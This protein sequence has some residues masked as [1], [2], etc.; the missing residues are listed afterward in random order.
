MKN[1][2]IKIWIILF[3]L[4]TSLIDI[5]AQTTY[6]FNYTG[7][8]QTFT[9]PTSGEYNI[10]ALGA[11][12]GN[13]ISYYQTRGGLGGRTAGSIN[14]TA[15]Q[16]IYIYVGGKSADQLGNHPY[17][18]CYFMLGGWNGGGDNRARGNGTAGGGASDVRIGG[19]NLNNRIIVAGG[20]G[21]AGWYV[22]NGGHGGGLTGGD[23]TNW[24]QLAASGGGTQVNGGT[25]GQAGGPCGKSSGSFGQGGDGSGSSAGGGGGG[26]G[27]YGGGGGGFINGGGGGSSYIGGVLNGLAERGVHTG[28]GRVIITSL[29]PCDNLIP[30]LES[31]P[32]INAQCEVSTLTPPSAINNC[33][34]QF[35]GTPNVTFPITTQGT[36]VVTWTYDDGN[37]N[38]ATQTQNVIIN[39]SEAPSMSFSDSSDA[40]ITSCETNL[41]IA[42]PTVG[43]NCTVN[44]ALDFDGTND[45]IIIQDD[46]SLDITSEITIEAWIRPNDISGEKTIL[47]KGTSNQCQNYLLV[48]RDGKLAYGSNGNCGWAGQG[49]N[50]NITAD[51]WQH[52]AAVAT[53]N[54]LKLYINGTLK[55]EIPLFSHIGTS[56]NENLWIGN[57][58]AGLNNHF[59]GQI[60]EVRIWNKARSASEIA[61]DFDKILNGSE[62]GLVAYYNFEDG[63]G[64]TVL[65]DKSVNANNGVLTNMAPNT[66]WISADAPIT[67]VS[68]TNSFTGTSNASGIYPVGET[69]VTWTAT[70]VAGN[71]NTLQQ[72]ITAG[73]AEAPEI[74]VQDITVDAGQVNCEAEVSV[75]TPVATDNCSNGNSLAFD[76]VDDFVSLG[77][78]GSAQTIEFWMNAD[79]SFDPSQEY[80]MLFNFNN[81]IYNYIATGN[82]TG[83]ISGETL[84]I[85]ALT[86]GGGFGVVS[87][88]EELIGW[89]HIA[90]V[91]N[92]SSYSSIYVNGNP[93]TVYPSG[94]ASVI[95]INSGFIGQ[96]IDTDT[97]GRYHG[98]LDEVRFWNVSRSGSEIKNN[99]EKE[100]SSQSGIIALYNFNQGL[101]NGD[102]V[103]V[104][105]LSDSSGNANNGSLNNFEIIG[106][107]SNWVGGF[108]GLDLIN[109]I[110]GT[111]NASGLYP[112]GDTEITWTATD[113]SGNISTATQTITVEDNT[114]PNAISQNIT[115]ELDANGQASI[116]AE[117]MN[118][119]STDNCEIASMELSQYDFDCTDVISNSNN[120]ALSFDGVDDYV[121]T[122]YSSTQN[123]NSF[124]IEAW[125]KTTTTSYSR[126]VTKPAGGGQNY[127]LMLWAGGYPHIRF[128]GNGGQF[129]Q[130]NTSV[131]DGQ[132]HHLAGVHNTVA[133]TITIY[134]DGVAVNTSNV[135]GDPVTSSEPLFIGK[136]SNT[137]NDY[138]NGEIDEVRL[139]NIPRSASEISSSYNQSLTGTEIG[140]VS[141]Y[142]FDDGSGTVLT[143]KTGNSLNGTLQ[144]MDQ[145]TDWVSGVPAIDIS[146]SEVVLTVTDINGNSSTSTSVVTVEDNLAPIVVGKNIE[147]T[148]T[149]TG[150]VSIVSEDVLDNGSDN[151]GE[152]T[153]ALSQDEFGA[154]DAIDSPVTIQLI[155]TDAHGNETS[156]PVIITVIDP[157]PN[158]VC[159]PIKVFLDENG[160]ITL[161]QDQIDQIG[162]GS[163]SVVG[164]G[165]LSVNINTFNC[166]NIGENTVILTVE[167]TLG[168]TATCEAVVTVEDN[169][170]PVAIAKD[171]T[172]QLD[173]NG[174]ASITAA[175]IDNGSNDACG[176]ASLALSKTDFNCSN[177]GA[178]TVTL[179]VTDNN[180][181]V[182]T[183]TA[184]ITV[185]DNVPP[186]AIAK[187]ITVQLDANGTASITAADID[188]G[189]NDAC[190]IAS[191]ALDIDSFT[192]S[193]VGDNTVVLTVTDNNGN[194]SSASAI[195]DVQDTIPAEVITQNIIAQLDEFGNVSIT[196]EDID[197][198]SND[199]CGIASLALD[200]DSFTC[201][202]VGDNTVVL[203][204]TDNNG[205]VSSASAIVDVQD[206]VPAEVITQNIIAQLDEF[207]NVSI[208]PEDIDNGSNDACGIASLA[209]D[210]DS[211]TCSNVGDNTVVLTVTD[212][213]GNVSS[214]SAIVDVQDTIPAE[215]ITQNIVAQLDEFG[216]VSITPEDIDNGSNDACG[217]AS[218]ALDIDSFTCSN[219]GDNTVVLTVTD[220]NGNVS[221]ASAIVDV[222]DTIPA[223][224]ITQNIVAQLD[225]FG[226]VSITPEDIDNGSND[227]CGIA[228]L[229]LDIDS[230]TCSNVGDN[231]VVL[232][233]TDNNGNVS[234]ASAIVDVQDTVPAE[235]ITQNIVAQLDEF[236]NVSITPEDIDNGSNDACGIA[237]LALDIDSFTCSNVGDNTVVL[238]V[239]DNN[240]NV[241]SASAIVDVQDTIPAEVI[242]Q[243]IIAQLDEFGNVS[244]TPED[245]DNGSNDACGIASL[246]LD[247]DS[248]TCSNVGDNTVVLTVTDN[249][250]N[251]SSASAI[252][253][254]QDTVPAE[255]I[256]Q[257]IIAQLDEFGNV[258]ITPEDIDN[259]SNDA[260]GI[261]SLALDIDSFTCSNVG[262]N[263]VVLTVTDNNGNVSSASAI[264]DV[265]DTVPAEVI[266]QNIVAQLDEFGNVS[267][268]PEDIDNGSNDA[269]GIASLA[270]DIDSFTCSNVGDNT[271]VL[272]VTDNNGNVSSASAIVDVQDTV[273]AEVITQNIIAQLDEFGNVSITPEDIDNGSNDACGI[274]SLALDIDSF[275][276]SEV[277]DNTVVLTVTDNNGNVSTATANVIVEDNVAPIITC[278]DNTARYIDPYQTYYTVQGAEFNATATDACGI[279]S[280]TYEGGVTNTNGSTMAGVQLDLGD[281]LMVWTVVDVNGNESDCTTVITV[282][283]RPTTLTY[284]GDLI[285]QYSD[286]VHLSATLIDDVSGDGV[287]GKTIIFTIGTQST[288]AIT[289]GNGIASTT[290]I[291]SQDPNGTYTVEAEFVEDASYLESS[292]EEVFDITQENAI[293]EY[294]G[295][296]LQ[297]TPSSSSSEAIV[298]LS[299]NIQDITV[300]D[301]INDPYAGDIRNAKVKFV[302]R[303]GGDI[304]GWINVVNLVDPND[305]RTGAVTFNWE[306]NIGTSDS[307]S[308]TIG[309]VVDNGYYIRNSSDDNVVVTVYKPNGDFITGG[310][311]IKPTNSEG[312]YAS[313]PGLKT[314][315]GF[316]VKYNKKGNKLKGHMNV[317]FRIQ[318]ND[319]IHT[320]QIKGNAIES[321]G[322]NVEDDENQTAEFIT[323]AN[324][325]DITDPLNTVSL[326]GNLFLKVEIS[327][328]GEPGSNDLIGFNLTRNGEL[329]YSSNWTGIK[330]SQMLLSGGNVVVHSG[331]NLG[332]VDGDGSN[333]GKSEVETEIITLAIFEVTAWPNPSKDIFNISLKSMNNDDK[334]EVYVFDAIGKLVHFAEGNASQ[335]YKFGERF[336]SGVYTVRVIQS[337]KIEFKRLIK[338]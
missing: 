280:L 13:V 172:V 331:F 71:T 129:V 290:L 338:E 88:K 8:V 121:N 250:G 12:A 171:I 268:T 318:E 306:V 237:S 38:T 330:T 300:S 87:I 72:T 210:I 170:P 238:T 26:G 253:D 127:S 203:T 35:T 329:Y 209:L 9:V 54:T 255:V 234:S 219:V 218:L 230:F 319:G 247:I 164:I 317:I 223:E 201:S 248:F 40:N 116:T 320:Y 273:P 46:N 207:G 257:N 73:D 112:L 136:F 5:N 6:T 158:A 161:S 192:C 295:Q 63:L 278:I 336:A 276:C 291:L 185:E 56:N 173:A 130:G 48:V 83:S 60:D 239:T 74:T 334:V 303:E 166:D 293:V 245:I 176:I 69:I 279:A 222:Q 272:T 254:V 216:N 307:E 191:L 27:W 65:S 208:T 34:E 262:D 133:N 243:N 249:N 167:S 70:D 140:L 304:S 311:Y 275:T 240:G 328:K 143:D 152:V 78:L 260:C 302:N 261:A 115:V 225:E 59:N 50:A 3:G 264:V 108:N 198:G 284:T 104:T 138:F 308:T 228:S 145:T 181:N 252:V 227:A 335:N 139:W 232:T 212:N 77:S 25:M 30:D 11:S 182:S 206:T 155:G 64:S 107:D 37:G 229:A 29:I 221:S 174:V 310:G 217:I 122:T 102:N 146:G 241:S 42:S 76:G 312:I 187:D 149:E 202:N 31:L 105:S 163:N 231:T 297:A 47:I 93:V 79:A 246:A 316:N 117:Q 213:N 82:I 224:V 28:N 103:G 301:G 281:N 17:P 62:L 271:V 277:G 157:V 141:Y 68:L 274:A 97:V 220:N 21:G 19:Q 41:N 90:I 283:K 160:T 148:L 124:T 294:T 299:A 205:N 58:T 195:V 193:N 188:N 298:V 134:V 86:S 113:A 179:T 289:N 22:A 324:L 267:I 337:D 18:N 292:D 120:Y 95:N 10:E 153:Y 214:A 114:P 45:S 204:V 144:N 296:S 325:T 94:T 169:V 288:S 81:S 186:V 125:V 20:G 23:S 1:Y 196:P 305:I 118:N 119:G 165:S 66:D 106:N 14:L 32:N 287:E 147:V 194:V 57:S 321:L 98:V 85:V 327:D 75:P 235:V 154:Q 175:D 215:V 135:N 96:R 53:S 314:N 326:G 111:I 332:S 91:S 265:Q 199:A 200:I 109:N 315:F 33:G 52:V 244:I 190:G 256:T 266:T 150:T 313:T 43:D 80:N 233:V 24:Y 15:G 180:N 156:V 132:W 55:D 211:F 89:N 282:Q 36:T 177:V 99:Y 84:S 269:C 92:G 101:T 259:G 258:S 242:T 189:S 285:E 2:Y 67:N 251:V 61:S 137:Y 226:N 197:N 128:D 309:I 4:I 7:N 236:G 126:I 39:D 184:V 123:L 323:K 16:I 100:L 178:N 51:V 142:N 151:C 183:A 162:E 44:T 286:S 322:V 49:V 110:T 333:G 270:L 131:N 263:T 168:A 159:N